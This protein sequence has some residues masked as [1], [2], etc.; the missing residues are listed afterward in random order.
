MRIRR[1]SGILTRLAVA[2]TALCTF[3]GT[4]SAWD[5]ERIQNEIQPYFGVWGGMYMVETHDLERVAGVSDKFFSPVLPAIGGSLGVAYGRLHVGFNSGYQLIDGDR[6][7]PG[8]YYYRYQ[9]VPTDLSIDVAL[10]PNETP[11]N[12]LVGASVG[13]GLVGIQNPISVIKETVDSTHTRYSY[14]GNDWNWNNFLLS[15]FYAGARINLARRLNLEGQLGYR[16]L[17][18]SEFELGNSEE[19]AQVVKETVVDSSG[20]VQSKQLGHIPV[21]LSNF[22][23]RLDARWTFASGAERDEAR[24]AERVRRMNEI[25]ALSPARFHVSPVPA[26]N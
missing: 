7:A 6:T 5:E 8:A 12:L 19:L 17:K 21:D 2:G 9:V 16:V 11:I 3:A 14:Y 4:A 25:L 24:A 26:E 10:L 1:T 15:T 13:L 18:S 20:K 22:Y 23:L